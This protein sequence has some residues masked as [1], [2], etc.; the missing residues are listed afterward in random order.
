MIK[1]YFILAFIIAISLA[2]QAQKPVK[3]YFQQ[4]VGYIISV[5]LDDKHDMLRA[6]ESISYKN[7]SSDTLKALYFHLWPN[8]YKD[9]N[10]NFA[11][12]KLIDGKSDFYFSD[13]K[14]RG[15]IDSLDFKVNEQKVSWELLKNQED[16]CILK[17][18][19][20]LLPSDSI[21][22]STPFR[23]KLPGKIFSRSGKDGDLYQ[24][25][26]W[27]PK[28]AVYDNRG[29][30]Y[31]SF[32]DQGEFYSEFG[33]F[34]VDITLPERYV[35]AATGDLGHKEIHNGYTTYAYF[36]DKVHDFA[37]FANPNYKIK[38]ATMT[39]PI[40]GKEIL[41][42]AYYSSSETLWRDEIE[43]M[44]KTVL[45]YSRRVGDYPYS[46]VKVVEV[47]LSNDAAMEYPTICTVP[48]PGGG[49]N[50][51]LLTAHEIGHNWFYGILASNERECP[52]MDE[53]MNSFME[54]QYVKENYGNFALTFGGVFQTLRLKV[55]NPD[56]VE[57]QFIYLAQARQHND[58]AINLHSS[59]YT[60]VNYFGIIYNKTAAAFNYLRVYLGDDLFY[61]CLHEYYNEWSF[62]HPYLEDVRDIFEKTSGKNLS[63]FF[64]DILKTTKQTDYGIKKVDIQKE[65]NLVVLK[66]S[67]KGNLN[68]PFSVSAY[69]G[70]TFLYKQWLDGSSKKKF[71]VGMPYNSA[72]KF[73]L[74]EDF[75]TFDMN[76]HN[77]YK[78]VESNAIFPKVKLKLLTGI[79]LLEKHELY[80]FP[81]IAWNVYDRW[82]P[83]IALYNKNLLEKKTEFVLA[84]MY[85][86]TTKSVNGFA[87][88]SHTFYSPLS[89]IHD[90]KVQT[91]AQ[92]FS[93]ANENGGLHYL[94]IN[95]AVIIDFK[96]HADISSITHTL[97]F[98]YFLLGS[99]DSKSK[100]YDFAN[101]G[102]VKYT[103]QDKK[104]INPWI[105]NANIE[106]TKSYSKLFADFKK[107]FMYTSKK[108]LDIRL[109]AGMFVWQQ[110]TY[111]GN[112]N[113]RMSGYTG[114]NDYLTQDL[115]FGRFETK[116]VLSQQF[117]ERDGN[118]K[119]FTFI[120]QTNKWLTTMNIETDLPGKIPIR[121]FADIGTYYKAK[122]A[123]DGSS[124]FPYDAGLSVQ[125]FNKI[126]KI[127]AP[128]I[129]SSDIKQYNQLVG[130]NFWNRIRF[131]ID[132]K[133]VNPFNIMH[134]ATDYILQ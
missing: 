77:N 60:A 102:V 82:M 90:I 29:W 44:R 69:N 50:T 35:L 86:F 106:F 1:K 3:P 85:S 17:L 5:S 68:M 33:S 107:S 12:Y 65:A 73:I 58:Q 56:N 49:G 13:K 19:N 80:Y 16:V 20:P 126:V 70:N 98:D 129:F 43:N 115:F 123:Y 75:E 6:Y 61:K 119:A 122:D 78:S 2:S 120:G 51:E 111:Y 62:K 66:I 108:S 31:F 40:S 91:D 92:Q 28:P 79:D 118:F 47:S 134:H 37:W 48:T 41:L 34:K 25:T 116:G 94:K 53:G 45:T 74:D 76:R 14:D 36:Q 84:P 88:I 128:L 133:R 9:E 89:F 59:A 87:N 42:Q 81:L 15:F 57:R 22:I 114:A 124:Q 63:W 24:V 64:D 113:F 30:H 27:Y 100:A 103:L 32:L 72:T 21:L 83:G 7:N 39:L 132:L 96:K 130:N 8:G 104:V 54:Q 93:F 26:Q 105:A 121:L 71:T 18:N 46:T 23:V 131:V 110:S 99:N 97:R 109:F 55:K 11:K 125:L 52:W 10:T 117:A 4:H 101:T 112:Y 38:Q 95:P 67:N 127:Y